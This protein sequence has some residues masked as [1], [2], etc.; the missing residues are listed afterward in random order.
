ML[1]NRSG[2]AACRLK[3]RPA[4]V[5]T[6]LDEFAALLPCRSF[7]VRTTLPFNASDS[8]SGAPRFENSGEFYSESTLEI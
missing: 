2:Y 4:D 3:S 5:F 8:Y 1:Q 6:R 7:E